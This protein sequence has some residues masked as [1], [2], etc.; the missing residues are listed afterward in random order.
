[1]PLPPSSLAA[2][3]ALPQ[4]GYVSTADPVPLS[5]KHPLAWTCIVC[6]LLVISTR[7]ILALV[8]GS[9]CCDQPARSCVHRC[10]CLCSIADVDPLLDKPAASKNFFKAEKIDIT[11][12]K[13][14]TACLVR[15]A[16]ET[17]ATGK[18]YY[19]ETNLYYM[20][21][22]SGESIHVQLGEAKLGS[23][24]SLLPP[25]PARPLL[26]QPSISAR[27]APPIADRAC[28]L[29]DIPISRV[30]LPCQRFHRCCDSY[31]PDNLRVC[32]R[33]RLF[34]AYPTS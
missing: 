25:P 1:M 16:T 33:S 19:G 8:Y 30:G 13:Q 23:P 34:T 4:S 2:R 29:G 26:Q 27:S 28:M 7:S 15:T 21:V 12:N 20:G 31:S 17:D 6:S 32:P 22:K 3:A 14:G 10:G 11:W 24:L 9:G 5:T 18:S